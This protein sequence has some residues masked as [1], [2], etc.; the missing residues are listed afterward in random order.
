MHNVKYDFSSCHVDV[1]NPL[2]EEIIKWGKEN[3]GDDDIYV[4]SH[5]PTF[6]REDE[7]H[8]TILYGIHTDDPEEIRPIL[9]NAGPVTIRLGKV[10]V[11]TN[12][13]KFDVV[14]IEVISEDLSRLH[15]QIRER[16]PSTYK[17]DRYN[18]HVTISY[19]KKGKGWRHRGID[20][21]EG[22]EFVCN[23]SIFSAKN[24]VKKVFPL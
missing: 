23:Y 3:V 22:R 14:M 6:G 15:W 18:P 24:G 7:I 20:L 17:Y 9:E 8:I 19:V 13:F 10:D 12:P 16:L 4:T 21:W 1:P 5:D 2:A 11:F